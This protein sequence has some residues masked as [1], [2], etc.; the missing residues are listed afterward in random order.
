MLLCGQ[1]SWIFYEY[2]LKREAPCSVKANTENNYK[3]A[4]TNV[5][6]GG[7][8]SLFLLLRAHF[9]I[10]LQFHIVSKPRRSDISD[11]YFSV[12]NHMQM[13]RTWNFQYEIA[14]TT[15]LNLAL[16]VEFSSCNV[17]QQTGKIWDEEFEG[18]RRRRI[19]LL[20]N[21]TGSKSQTDQKKFN[22]FSRKEFF[23]SSCC[24]FFAARVPRENIFCLLIN[25]LFEERN[26]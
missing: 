5:W 13:T 12:V 25:L 26:N 15:H 21:G 4:D 19:S 22:D 8:F 14:I 23:F 6:L 24:V 16:L 1:S 3:S 7:N 2:I 20:A 11:S 10:Y 9:T 18:R 17:W